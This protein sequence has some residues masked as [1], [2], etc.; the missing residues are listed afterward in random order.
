MLYA[1]LAMVVLIYA[2]GIFTAYVRIS[3]IRQKKIKARY[4]KLMQGDDV[5][6][7]ITKT[8][9]Q[10]NNLFEV[11]V[12]FFVAGVL[13]LIMKIESTAG[14]GFAWA[15][16]IARVLQAYI[17]LGYNNP[18]HRMLAFNAGNICV[19]ALWIVVAINAG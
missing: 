2:V 8:T 1:M 9:R 16:V 10:F 18:L 6:E 3:S 14:L 7:I 5:P 19:I 17:H 15:F 4:F 13:Y 11:P 12:L